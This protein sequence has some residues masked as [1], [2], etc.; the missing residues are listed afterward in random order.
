MRHGPKTIRPTRLESCGDGRRLRR[1]DAARG[2]AAEQMTLEEKAMQLSC[3]VPI[4]VLGRD[5]LMR[6]QADTLL[7]HG[8]GHIAGPGLIGHKTPEPLAKSV[9]ET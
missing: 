6:N 9:S 8:I 7:K 3:V 2:R 5:G 4:A 1:G